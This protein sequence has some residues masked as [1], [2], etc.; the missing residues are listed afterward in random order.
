MTKKELR[1]ERLLSVVL[2]TL[3]GVLI[4]L[5]CALVVCGAFALWM[6]WELL[7][8]AQGWPRLVALCAPFALMALL[9]LSWGIG[10]SI[11]PDI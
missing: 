2:Q 5:G 11:F 7:V 3:M 9:L 1:T 6:A 4:L 10:R 8:D